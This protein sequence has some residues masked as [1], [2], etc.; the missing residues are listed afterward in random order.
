MTH[1]YHRGIDIV[2]VILHMKQQSAMATWTR[3]S[4]GKARVAWEGARRG[5]CVLAAERPHNHTYTY[6]HTH[7]MA[8]TAETEWTGDESGMNHIPDLTFTIECPYGMFP[9]VATI[10]S[11]GTAGD[12]DSI[13]IRDPGNNIITLMVARGDRTI[14]E[15]H[16]MRLPPLANQRHT[17]GG[18]T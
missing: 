13:M 12:L 6:T 7:I 17:H 5:V 9:R 14:E 16:G 1:N 10:C 15:I 2:H 11:T 3:A 4:L 18:D 8:E